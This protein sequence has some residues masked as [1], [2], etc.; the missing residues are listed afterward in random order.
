MM[1]T[2]SPFLRPASFSLLL[3]RAFALQ[4]LPPNPPPAPGRGTARRLPRCG[5]EG[6]PR[7]AA[8]H[9]R[10]VSRA[11][12][13]AALEEGQPKGVAPSVARW[14]AG[15]GPQAGG[16]PGRLGTGTAG[17]G[18]GRLRRRDPACRTA[19]TAACNHPLVSLA[20]VPSRLQP[21]GPLLL[22]GCVLHN[23]PE[24]SLQPVPPLVRG[25]LGSWGPGRHCEAVGGLGGA[26]AT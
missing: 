13:A 4:L 9:A 10:A 14:C 18:P 12:V 25:E 15:G 2:S 22:P 26:G 19:L 5:A 24:R 17:G 16:G 1:G 11:A 7:A 23:V 20:M 3:P 21:V 6:P 8:W